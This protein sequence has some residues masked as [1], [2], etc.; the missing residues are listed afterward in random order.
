MKKQPLLLIGIVLIL[1]ITAVGIYL[2]TQSNSDQHSTGELDL[3]S[4]PAMEVETEIPADAPVE[5]SVS[6]TLKE[7][8]KVLQDLDADS[9]FAGLEDF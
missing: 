8:D 9:D 4:V 1:I 3:E 2:Y 5:E 6:Q 7:L